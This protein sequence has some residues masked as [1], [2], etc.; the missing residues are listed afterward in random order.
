M[1]GR[2]AAAIF[3]RR[4][5][6]LEVE[7]TADLQRSREIIPILSKLPELNVRHSCIRRIAIRLMSR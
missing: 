5:R 2:R 1:A 7:F 6:D 3:S 4:L